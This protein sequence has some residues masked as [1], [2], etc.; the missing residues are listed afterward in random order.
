MASEGE[1]ELSQHLFQCVDYGLR[2]FRA[3]RY[4]LPASPESGHKPIV[5]VG[6]FIAHI[7]SVARPCKRPTA[8][9][10]QRLIDRADSDKLKKAR[11]RLA[12]AADSEGPPEEKP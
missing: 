2:L 9:E 3:V 4:T 12:Q 5:P 6:L 10:M 7:R 11:E 1:D 8:E